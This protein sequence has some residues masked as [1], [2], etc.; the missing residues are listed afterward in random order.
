MR[1][2][3]EALAPTRTGGEVDASSEPCE[4]SAGANSR[5]TDMEVSVPQLSLPCAKPRMDRS[6][7][8]FAVTKRSACAPGDSRAERHPQ[9]VGQVEPRAARRRVAVPELEEPHIAGL[10]ARV[11]GAGE[12]LRLVDDT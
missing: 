9:A 2:E 12:V 6:I 1:R 7:R 11:G 5:G 10:D 4:A 8:G 3:W